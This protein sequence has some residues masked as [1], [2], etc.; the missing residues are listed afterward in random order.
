MSSWHECFTGKDTF[1]TAQYQA[2]SLHS[3]SLAHHSPSVTLPLHLVEG[4]ATAIALV[5][6]PPEGGIC[7]GQAYLVRCS[8]ELVTALITTS[9]PSFEGGRQMMGTSR[10]FVPAG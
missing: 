7:Y 10:S 6:V 3:G 9:S 4:I 1:C 5:S 8:E 2:S